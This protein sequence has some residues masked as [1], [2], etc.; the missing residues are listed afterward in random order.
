M[1]LFEKSRPPRR[2]FFC[3][4]RSHDDGF[5]PR[6]RRLTIQQLRVDLPCCYSAISVSFACPFFPFSFFIP[7]MT[8]DQLVAHRRNIRQKLGATSSF[9]L[10]QYARAFN[11]I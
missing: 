8:D 1:P 4:G 10:G 9:D 3:A 11:L 2:D 6:Q 7:P 5:Y